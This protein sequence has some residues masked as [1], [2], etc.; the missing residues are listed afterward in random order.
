MVT[1]LVQLQFYPFYSSVSTV[2]LYCQFFNTEDADSLVCLFVSLCV[3]THLPQI[4]GQ[5][6][7][8]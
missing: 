7:W 5:P 6:F 1:V 4:Y 3:L 2:A 8:G